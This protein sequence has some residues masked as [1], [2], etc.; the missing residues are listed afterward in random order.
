MTNNEQDL[1]SSFEIIRRITGD[2]WKFLIITHLF[3]GKKRF[4]ELQYHIDS[5][6]KKV[7]TENLRELENYGI[8]FRKECPGVTPK[9]E[10]ALTDIGSSLQPVFESLIIWSLG[11]SNLYKE[12]LEE[13]EKND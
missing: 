12:Q 9:T 7:L 8:V 4:G 6:T 13:I 2:K 10:Y 3:N 1:I 11:Y 5:I